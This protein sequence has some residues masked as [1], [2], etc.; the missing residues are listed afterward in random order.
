MRAIF[1]MKVDYR[2]LQL[3]WCRVVAMRAVPY[4]L[5][6][7][8]STPISSWRDSVRSAGR[9]S[10]PQTFLFLKF[11]YTPPQFKVIRVVGNLRPQIEVV[12][13]VCAVADMSLV[14]FAHSVQSAQRQ[15][16]SF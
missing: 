8:S 7:H 15:H 14:Q 4:G 3:L 1:T 2:P 12:S 9:A 6:C 5:F 16:Y 11:L 10:T 13:C